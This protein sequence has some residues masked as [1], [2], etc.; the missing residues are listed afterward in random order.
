MTEQF[1]YANVTNKLYTAA[2]AERWRYFIAQ[3]KDRG[4]NPGSAIYLE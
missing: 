2:V 3:R 1:N 4:S